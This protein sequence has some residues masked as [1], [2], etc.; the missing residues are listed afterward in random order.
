MYRTFSP[1]KVDLIFKPKVSTSEAVA[2]MIALA[3]MLN[4]TQKD[5]PII[6]YY[7]GHGNGA[8]IDISPEKSIEIEDL[9]C[10]FGTSEHLKR[11][12]KTVLLECCRDGSILDHPSPEKLCK[13]LGSVLL[14][15]ATSHE[16][17][18]EGPI[19]GTC[20]AKHFQEHLQI[21][22][23]VTNAND[24]VYRKTNQL[25]ILYGS[26]GSGTL[27]LRAIAGELFHIILYIPLLH[28]A[29]AGL[30]T[31]CHESMVIL[32]VLIVWHYL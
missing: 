30:S 15:Y 19:W 12:D 11:I 6:V 29:H 4:E 5:V 21:I 17:S 22:Q 7:Y 27:N 23:V 9:L 28:E 14:A 18:A 32:T 31:V 16:S 1:L 8:A 20:L 25:P 10:P 24:E 26:G 13:Y 3:D 2:L